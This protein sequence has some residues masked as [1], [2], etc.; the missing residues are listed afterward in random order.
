MV[1]AQHTHVHAA[2][3]T[4]AAT[5]NSS[6]YVN[7]R[8]QVV[9]FF[10]CEVTQQNSHRLIQQEQ[11]DQH[12][13]HIQCQYRQQLAIYWIR[14]GHLWKRAHVKPR[15]DLYIPRQTDAGRNITKLET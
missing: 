2:T 4:K 15:H 3:G 5:E 11:L 1:C 9:P 13:C 6:R 12:Q 10:V 7:Q 14:E 8:Q